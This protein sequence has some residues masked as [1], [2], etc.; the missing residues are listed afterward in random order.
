M[1]PLIYNFTYYSVILSDINKHLLNNFCC[2]IDAI[3]QYVKDVAINDNKEGK[4]VTYLVVD[5]TRDVVVAY[6]TLSSTSLLCMVDNDSDNG[7]N[8]NITI[9]G[10]SAVEIKLFAVNNSYQDTLCHDASLGNKLI[11]DII[12]GSIIGDIYNITLNILGAEV[13]MLYSIPSAVDF[14][15]RN[16]FLPLDEYKAFH[17]DFTED[18]VPMYLRLF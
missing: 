14:Y 7:H 4:G 9:E 8:D 2:G 1:P 5:S 6:Y 18:C 17:S 3:D 11:S 12:L 10:I 15:E 13:I 16:Q